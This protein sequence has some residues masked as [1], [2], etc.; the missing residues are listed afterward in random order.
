MNP[1]Y[2]SGGPVG[3]EAMIETH[4]DDR[5]GIRELY[6]HSGP[7]I[8]VVDLANPGYTTGTIT[9]K[10]VPAFFSPATLYP[11]ETLTLRCVIENFGNSNEFNVNQGFYLSTDEFI[12]TSDL[13]LGELRWDLPMGDGF[14][15]DMDID[16][17]DDLAAGT[18]Y[19]GSIFDDLNEVVEEYED[20]N[21]HVYRDTLNVAQ[22]TPVIDPLGQHVAP[23]GAVYVGP[24]PTVSHP[25]NM[26][27]LTL[28]HR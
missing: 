13:L 12:D 14:D 21:T 4:T 5:N 15:Y 11:A 9:G 1:R 27:P 28:E 18:Y 8:T 22:L 17:P 6:P 20:N 7:T 24:A 23:C 19:V 2:P 16:L 10:A 25:L 26:A 3:A